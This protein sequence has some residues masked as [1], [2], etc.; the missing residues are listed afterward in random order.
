M[1][2]GRPAAHHTCMDPITVVQPSPTDHPSDAGRPALAEAWAGWARRTVDP[3][4]TVT[5]PAVNEARVSWLVGA[6]ATTA[7]SRETP[8][9]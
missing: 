1:E 7:S 8:M 4:A 6:S 5:S 2:V 9:P 3:R